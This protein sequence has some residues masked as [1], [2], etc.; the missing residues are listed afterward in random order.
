MPAGIDCGATCTA[1]FL[2]GTDVTL[3]ATA[4][5]GSVFLGWSN[6]CIGLTSCQ[7]TPVTDIQVTATFAPSPRLAI[8]TNGRNF[9]T[10]DVLTVSVGVENPGLPAVV[11]FYFGALLPDG[12]TVVFFTDLAFHS[13]TGKLSQPATLLPIVAGVD[14]T[15]PFMFSDYPFFIHR[16]M[17][18]E[19][20]GTYFLFVAAVKSGAL[21][22]NSIDPGDIVALSTATVSFTP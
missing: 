16:W 21:A 2:D 1:S 22:D 13:A 7:L 3:S 9:R 20:P 10:T 15:T 14:L 18:M 19:P 12:D 17:G 5:A 6:P 4:A 11:D 8:E